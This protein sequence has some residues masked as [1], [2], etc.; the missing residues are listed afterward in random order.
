[1]L[2]SLVISLYNEEQ[3]IPLFYREITSCLS[4]LSFTYELIMVDDGSTDNS[5]RILQSLAERDE[6]VKV[7][8]FS[9]NYGHEAAMIAG[10]DHSRGDM[11]IC[12]DVDL[13]HPPEMIPQMIK[14]QREG[15]DIITMARTDNPDRNPFQKFTSR[16]FYRVLN[17]LSGQKFDINASDFFLITKPVADILRNEFREQYRFLR[18]FIQLIGFRKT[19]MHY[20]AE[21]RAAGSSKYSL[22]HLFKY[23]FEVMLT[24]SNLPLKLGLISGVVLGMFGGLV[25]VWEII[26]R[27]KGLTPPGYATIVALISFLFAILFIIIGIIGEYIAVLFKEVKGRPIYIIEKEY[28]KSPTAPTFA[29]DVTY[30]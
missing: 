16:M 19:T 23:S 24:F 5:I 29:S 6:H 8:S 11:I 27:F 30:D 3:V 2:L 14:K 25:G 1:M 4:D 7:I 13:Q 20:K 17:S 18:G 12:M 28:A 26:M 22:M 21:A 15:Y 10:I 9:R